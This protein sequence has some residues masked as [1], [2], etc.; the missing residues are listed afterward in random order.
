M[1]ATNY[2]ENAILNAMRGVTFKSPATVYVGLFLSNPTDTGS[3]GTE[4]SYKGYARQP[5]SFSEPALSGVNMSIRNTEQVTFP[6]C[7]QSAG[8]VTYIGIMDSLVGGNMLA[9]GSLTEEMVVNSGYA[10]V[11]LAGDAEFYLA[12]AASNS[13]K[14]K[15]LNMFRGVA[16][17]GFESYFALFNGNPDNGGSELEGSNYARVPLALS[18]PAQADSG[19]AY[20][21]NAN[22][23]AFNRPSASWGSYSYA[24]IFNAASAGEPV[25]IQAILPVI[26]IKKGYMPMIAAGAVRV[27]IN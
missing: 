14:K 27:A 10:P 26:E 17:A 9:Y 18:A 8:T 6:A 7:E 11:I 12:G 25:W 13:F 2:L 1:Y 5:I 24:A 4:V 19:Q 15:I 21:T 16:L 20:V 3:A 23:V 22:D